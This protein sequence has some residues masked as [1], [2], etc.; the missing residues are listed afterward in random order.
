M[1]GFA[2]LA[3]LA[4]IALAALPVA[5]EPLVPRTA[6]GHAMQYLVS[7]PTG[8]TAGRRWPVLIVIPDATRAFRENAQAFVDAR[9]DRPFVIVA[10]MVLTSGGARFP[11]TPPL[12]P[13]GPLTWEDVDRNGPYRFD[14]DGLRAVLRDV[15]TKDAGEDRAYLTGWEAGGHTV[16]ALTFNHPEWFRAVAPVSSNWQGR[17]VS[18]PTPGSERPPVRVLFCD[19]PA[20]G[21]L[22]AAWRA[23]KEQTD[24]AIA[25]AARRGFTDVTLQ[26]LPGRTHG[27]LAPDVLGVFDSLR[28]PARP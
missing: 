23:L 13:Y 18:A 24:A 9:G 12:F 17:W 26:I 5:A 19:L 10:P 28:S 7:R 11:R 14:Q 20:T 15:R 1:R 8:W 27:P 3:A 4:A 6:A 22:A 25:E 16:W 21:D 2:P